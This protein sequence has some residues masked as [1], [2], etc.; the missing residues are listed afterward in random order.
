MRVLAVGAATVDIVNEVECYPTEDQEVRAVRQRIVRGGNAANLLVSL[1]QLGHACNWAGTI[2]D[3]REARYIAA[4]FERYAVGMQHAVTH[5]GG[6]T[7]VSYIALSR[8]SGSRTIVHYRELPEY[9][10]V[11]FANID[12][13]RYDWVH[14]EGRNVPE[15][16]P[17]LQLLAEHRGPPCSL[18]VEKPRVGIEALFAYPDLLLFGRPYIEA[19][20]FASADVFLTS[21]NLP[22]GRL[23][24]C[25]WGGQGA[26][27]RT[28]DGRVF[29]CPPIEPERLIDTLGAG[30]VFNAAVVDARVRDADPIDMVASGCRLAGRK[31][32]VLGMDG[33]RAI[34]GG[35]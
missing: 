11:H 22:A 23:A 7:P 19:L 16:A 28:R 21:A 31:C 26:W 14:F 32:G 1:S 27:G 35:D 18:E 29:H 24:V 17:M 34:A 13:E 6:R 2:A 8:Q 3:D 20:G 5:R 9:A 12:L 15:L 4:D 10:A 25:A 33:L 30:D